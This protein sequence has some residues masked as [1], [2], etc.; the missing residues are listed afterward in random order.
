MSRIHFYSLRKRKKWRNSIESL[1]CSHPYFANNSTRKIS[2]SWNQAL[3]LQQIPRAYLTDISNQCTPPTRSCWIHPW[4]TIK[5]L[6]VCEACVKRTVPTEHIIDNSI[7]CKSRCNECLSVKS[8]CSEC[9]EVGQSS[10]LPCL[11]ACDYCLGCG[12]LCKRIVFLVATA[13]CE[14]G[15]KKA[16]YIIKESRADQSIDPELS[17][18]SIIPDVPH[19]GKSLKAGSQIGF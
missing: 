10:Y 5:I 9:A 4:S 6:Q 7:A 8:V 18:L 12:I 1:K 3:K 16:F 15:N 2:P 19:V 11:R 13:D 14:E 17:L